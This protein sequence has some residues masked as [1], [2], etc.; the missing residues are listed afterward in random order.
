M[1]GTYFLCQVESIG[2]LC[3]GVLN[4]NGPLGMGDFLQDFSS[5]NSDIAI[6]STVYFFS[7]IIRF[8]NGAFYCSLQRH[9]PRKHSFGLHYFSVSRCER[10]AVFSGRRLCGREAMSFFQFWIPLVTLDDDDAVVPQ[11]EFQR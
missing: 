1:L 7:F 3:K 8:G 2:N 11:F 10:N 5:R 4:T 9:Q 6:L